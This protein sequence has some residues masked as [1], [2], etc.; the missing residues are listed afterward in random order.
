[1]GEQAEAKYR[2]ALRVNPFHV[3]SEVSLAMLHGELGDLDRAIALMQ[4][5]VARMPRHRDNLFQLGVMLRRA[6]R[7]AEALDAFR[8]ARDVNSNDEIE[9]NIRDLEKRALPAG[10]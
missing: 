1:M 9:Q 6:G 7:P 8:R 4:E 3:E 2:E 10:R 5:V